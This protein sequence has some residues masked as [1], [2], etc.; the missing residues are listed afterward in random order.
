MMHTTLLGIVV[1]CEYFVAA[2][3]SAERIYSSKSP[4]ISGDLIFHPDH[5]FDIDIVLRGCK[6]SVDGLTFSSP[7]P[8]PD[9]V[10]M[11]KMLISYNGTSLTNAVESCSNTKIK[12]SDFDVPLTG[13][14]FKGYNTWEDIYTFWGETPGNFVYRR[15]RF[16]DQIPTRIAV[17]TSSCQLPFRWPSGCI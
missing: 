14:F 7:V 5:T 16:L 15:R 8:V 11:Y 13:Y 4:L 17:V 9:M 10:M 6:I 3:P 1:C 12:I 2:S